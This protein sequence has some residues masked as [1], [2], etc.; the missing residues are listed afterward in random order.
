MRPQSVRLPLGA[1]V[2]ALALF[3]ACDAKSGDSASPAASSAQHTAFQPR[4]LGKEPPKW[5]PDLLR[6]ESSMAAPSAP[7][8]SITSAPSASVAARPSSSASTPPHKRAAVA[9]LKADL[10]ERGLAL[11]AAVKAQDAKQVE[12]ALL[13][14]AGTR[15]KVDHFF[16]DTYGSDRGEELTKEWEATIAKHLPELV[17]PFKDAV[18]KGQTDVVV[19][20]FEGPDAPGANPVQH[21]ALEAMRKP[22]PL[23]TMTLTKPG[24]S[25]GFSLWSFAFIDGRFVLVGKMGRATG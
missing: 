23:F 20:A 24:E 5:H 7:A 12:V 10:R 25:T 14:L 21:R 8:P 2:A 18:Q 19:T 17:M 15:E 13:E 16:R 11:L 3:T 6:T 1:L 22:V 9:D 4:L